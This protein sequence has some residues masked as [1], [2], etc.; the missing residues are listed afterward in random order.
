MMSTHQIQGIVLTYMAAFGSL[1]CESV[2]LDL[3]ADQKHACLSSHR[4]PNILYFDKEL[5]SSA[6]SV[7]FEASRVSAISNLP[8]NEQSRNMI[9][10]CMMRASKMN[11]YRNPDF[12]YSKNRPFYVFAVC[13]DNSRN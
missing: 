11:A 2:A 12:S 9:T 3:L 13:N 7:C 8:Q 6:S 4:L 10:S 1:A 5:P